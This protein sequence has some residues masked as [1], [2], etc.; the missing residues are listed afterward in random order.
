MRL[1]VLLPLIGLGALLALTSY[2]RWEAS[3]RAMR[4]GESL[5]SSPFPRVLGVG[6]GITA[7]AAGIGVM[8]EVLAR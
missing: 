8:I 1:L 6:V 4:L 5:P 2:R 3:E 7:L